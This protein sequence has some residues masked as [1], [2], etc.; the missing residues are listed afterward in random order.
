LNGTESGWLREFETSIQV[1]GQTLRTLLDAGE[2]VAALPDEV[3]AQAHWQAA[4]WKLLMA[5]ERG[6]PLEDAE[7]A[8][9]W[10]VNLGRDGPNELSPKRTKERM[11]IH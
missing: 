11:V 8:M 6:G 10:A 7:I 4:L 5:A 3:S 9:R 1:G 2:F